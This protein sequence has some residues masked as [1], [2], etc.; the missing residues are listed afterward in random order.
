MLFR[1]QRE[2]EWER[3]EY[4]IRQ[5]HLRCLRIVASRQQPP[6][7]T[8][9]SLSFCHS[10]W[11]S[12][13][14][15][16][17]RLRGRQTFL[18]RFTSIALSFT[19]TLFLSLSFPPFLSSILFT[20]FVDFQQFQLPFE[21]QPISSTEWQ[22]GHTIKTVIDLYYLELEINE[23]ERERERARAK[24]TDSFSYDRECKFHL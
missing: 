10:L 22:G 19:L 17:K 24:K 6:P 1:R 23:Q 13:R 4:F 7:F 9:P 14:F 5:C 16:L 21:W 11:F 12:V 18:Q 8:T 2:T 3:V 15:E 20:S